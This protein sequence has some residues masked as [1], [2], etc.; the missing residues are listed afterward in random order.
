MADLKISALT[1]STTPLAGTEVLPIVQSSTT[2]Q[3]SVANL[4]AGRAVSGLS[5]TGTNDST[6]NGVVV[7]RGTGSVS[8]NTVVGA[9]ALTANTSGGNCTSVGSQSLLLNTTGIGNTGFGRN[10]LQTNDTGSNNSAIGRNALLSVIGSNNSS[11]GYLAGSTLTSGDNNGFFGY[12][13]QPSSA[14][15]SNEYTY[16]DSAVTSHRF[17]GGNVVIGTSGKGIDFSATAGTGTS[18]LLADYEEGTWTPVVVGTT[19]AGTGTYTVQQAHYVKVG[20]VV[21][22]TLALGWSAHTG[23][24]NIEITGLPFSIPGSQDT[25]PCSVFC[26]GLTFLGQLTAVTTG[27]KVQL[28]QIAT[29][30]AATA[31]AMDTAVAALNISGFYFTS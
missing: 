7:G 16:G 17:V 15:V 4:T 23:T 28:Y 8:T 11:I 19:S 22:F 25:A 14:T 26:W 1:A 10:S 3:V 21:N 24:G 18:E 12:N 20:N 6:F 9:S 13:A 30:S 29:A 31:V 2:K 5:F 27:T